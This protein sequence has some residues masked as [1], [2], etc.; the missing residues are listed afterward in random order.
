MS[1]FICSSAS[2]PSTSSSRASSSSFSPITA[3]SA[4]HCSLCKASF[5]NSEVSVKLDNFA[6]CTFISLNAASIFPEAGVSLALF[7]AAMISRISSCTHA[8][9]P[10]SARLRWTRSMLC[11]SA[12]VCCFTFLRLLSSC[13]RSSSLLRASICACVI[14][15][16]LICSFLL[17]CSALSFQIET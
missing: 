16:E 17:C 5:L 7:T 8:A 15:L 4:I 9:V 11:A 6:Y 12:V 10:L 1:V 3:D 14:P 2:F 13:C